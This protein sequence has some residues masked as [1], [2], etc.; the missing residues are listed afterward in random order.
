M[1]RL[2]SLYGPSSPSPNPVR[3]PKAKQSPA[4]TPKTPSIYDRWEPNTTPPTETTYHRKLRTLL[5][6]FRTAVKTWNDLVLVDGLKAAKDLTDARTELDN[7]LAAISG[8][9]QPR[10]RLVTPKLAMMESRIEE[11]DNVIAKLRKQFDNMTTLVDSGDMLLIEA[12]KL[13]GVKWV[14]EEALWC[15]WPL[16]RFVSRL[17]VIL[18]P[19]HRALA[20]CCEIAEQLRSHSITFEDSRAALRQWI[21]QPCLAEGPWDDLEQLCEVEVDQWTNRNQ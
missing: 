8:E 17:A 3:P 10:L 6:D 18:P 21:A 16:E 19:Y 7:S 15:T 11:L 5:L 14:E 20:M 9:K 2:Q 1:S 4:K 13:K 12:C